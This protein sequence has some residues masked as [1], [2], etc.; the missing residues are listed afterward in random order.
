[1]TVRHPIA[2]SPTLGSGG[3]AEPLDVHLKNVASRCHLLASDTRL[4]ALG[5]LLGRW[6]DLGKYSEYFQSYI[7]GGG[8][9]SDADD[10][11]APGGRRVD[12]STF[13]AQH[14]ASKA[15]ASSAAEQ[16]RLA[17]VLAYCI[18]G[19]HCGLTDWNGDAHQTSHLEARLAKQLPEIDSARRNAPRSVLD[20]PIP[21]APGLLRVP[22]RGGD[23]ANLCAFSQ[24]M[25]CRMLFS[26]LIDA[27]RLETEAF[28]DPHKHGSRGDGGPTIAALARACRTYMDT[29]PTKPGAEAVNSVRAAVLAS[30]RAAADSAPG[31]FS[32]TVPTGGGKTFASLSFALDHAATHGLRRVIYAAPFTSIIEQNASRI[33]EALG[34]AGNPEAVL[35][36]HSAINTEHETPRSRLLTENW[37][38]P[39]IVTTNVQMLESLFAWTTSACRKVHRIAR[40]VII[41]DE[42]QTLPPHL[43]RPCI[44]ALRC[45]VE[46]HGCSIVLCTATQ[47]A[48]TKRE[49][50]S[51]GLEGVRE[52]MGESVPEIFAS[53]R[54]VRVEQ[55]GTLSD[56]ELAER[57]LAEPRCLCIV[58]SRRH[59]ATLFGLVR[60]RDPDAQHLSASMCPEHRSDVLSVIKNILNTSDATCRVISTQVIEAGVD[61]DFPVVFRAMAGLDSI[62]QAAGRCNREGRLP[63][64]GRTV[65]FDTE[66]NA[67][68]KIPQM[69]RLAAQ[70][71]MN[72]L[73]DHEDDPLG[74]H[75]IEHYFEL[76]Y[77]RSRAQRESERWDEPRVMQHFQLARPR[78]E[79]QADFRKA[80]EAFKLIDDWQVPIIVPYKRSPEDLQQEIEHAVASRDRNA[81]RK[82]Q[83][84]SVSVSE[85]IRHAMCTDGAV[86]SEHEPFYILTNPQAYD[87]QLGL[88]DDITGLSIE[89]QLF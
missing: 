25:H 30:C 34:S 57:L 24:S 76:V 58:N 27:D 78:G 15:H 6:H 4:A 48:L 54:R 53:L 19:H 52:M 83:R 35:E 43:L 80:A 65:V 22:A 26:C 70:D 40:S 64:P 31:F 33:R 49:T 72:V 45:L 23:K 77:A 2:H 51:I 46:E 84:L 69:I 55:A 13:G 44:A 18:A 59:A 60:A 63:Q 32:L 5:E 38:A 3:W 36:H 47:P 68:R 16:A 21:A 41:L 39:V 37:D 71:A 74:T 8:D 62:A 88:R 67:A 87:P 29:L 61:V 56:E 82:F 81:M 7:G 73:P 89:Q 85:R 11:A 10:D 14:A 50:F 28:S 20:M 66:W 1:M 42:A 79:L 75:A 9:D 86:S 17:R 12:H